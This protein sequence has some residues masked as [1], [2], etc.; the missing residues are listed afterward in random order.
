MRTLYEAPI[1]SQTKVLARVLVRLDLDVPIKNGAVLEPY[2]L[3]SALPTLQFLKQKGAKIIIAGHM[4]KPGGKVVPEL[5]T[6]HLKPFFDEHLGKD[7]YEL[8][9]NLRFDPGE[10]EN[11]PKFSEHLASMADAYVNESFA[12]CH[13][14]HASIVG[15]P[16]LLP[17]FAGMRLIQE[18]DTLSKV[19]KNPKKPLIAVVGGA[20]LESK[21]PVID[22]FLNI[23][24]AV[25]VGGKIGLNWADEVPDNLFLPIDYAEQNKDIG[26]S[27]IAGFK[28][29]LSCA[30]TVI[31]AGPLGLF[32]EDKF[33]TGTKTIAEFV[34]SGSSYKI[35]GGGDTIAALD[36]AGVLEKFDFISTGGGAMLDFLVKG[37]LPGLKV[38]GYNG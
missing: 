6:T 14:E 27:T 19:L 11:N 24:D 26:P 31:W 29:I 30:G 33:F 21:R 5:S 8:L 16:Q 2:R 3:E 34:A 23:A 32:E 22:K 25:L 4:G 13:R 36:K 7:N 28:E 37:N 35:A 15:V 18:V 10:E 1:T 12:T 9:E 17:S 20:K 38:L